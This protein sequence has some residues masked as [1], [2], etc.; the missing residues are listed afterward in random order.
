M[1]LVG[2]IA[3]E[4]VQLREHTA[5]GGQGKIHLKIVPTQGRIAV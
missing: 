4:V 1:V 5:I 2:S 3:H